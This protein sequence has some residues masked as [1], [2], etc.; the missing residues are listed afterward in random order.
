MFWALEATPQAEPAI[1]GTGSRHRETRVAEVRR[2]GPSGNFWYA[3]ELASKLRRGQVLAVVWWKT[4]IAIYRDD[5]G[6]VSA[7]RL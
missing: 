6:T 1:E 2:S 5:A 3:V 7:D 4:S